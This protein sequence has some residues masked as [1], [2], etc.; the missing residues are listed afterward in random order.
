M[1]VFKIPL[2]RW[3]STQ[4]KTHIGF[5]N[6]TSNDFVVSKTQNSRI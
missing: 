6:S 1:L 5:S 4:Q 3:H 2:L